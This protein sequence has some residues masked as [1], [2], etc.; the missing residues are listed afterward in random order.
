MRISRTPGAV[1]AFVLAAATFVQPLAAGAVT[2]GMGGDVAF[3]SGDGVVRLA[4]AD[5][6]S[7]IDLADGGHPVWSPDGRDLAFVSAA[8]TLRV[9]SSGVEIAPIEN[10]EWSWSPDGGSIAWVS[11][12]GVKDLW[13]T[14]VATATSKN[15]TNGAVEARSPQ[16]LPDGRTI[17]FEGSTGSG[18]HLWMVPAA[19]GAA[20]QVVAGH[21]AAVSS[22]GA[23]IALWSMDDSLER[24][25]VTVDRTGANPIVLATIT[26]C[27]FRRPSWSPDDS[28][29]GYAVACGGS[30]VLQAIEF[31]VVPA[32]GGRAKLIGGGGAYRAAGPFWSPTG[33]R[34]ALVAGG[35]SSRDVTIVD[36][37]GTSPVVL[38][39]LFPTGSC[40]GAPS[41]SPDGMR[42]A[43]EAYQSGC[44]Q[45]AMPPPPPAEI[46]LVAEDGTGLTSLG[47][48]AHPAWRPAPYHVGLVD[49]AQGVWHLNGIAPFYFGNPGDVPFL[50]D[51]D[52]DGVATPG[53]YRQSDG[54]VYLRNSNTQG[55][56]DIRFF[57]GNPG[58]IP[59][60]GDFDGDGI[61]TVSVYRPSTGEVFVI[62]ELGAND[63][64]LGA[65]EFA[66]YFGNP[67]DKPF[68][69]DFD[70]DG[71]D[72][73][74]LHRESTG[75]V[76]LRNSHTGGIADLSF[77]F[78]N[79]GDRLVAG[80]WTGD[81]HET[82]GVFRPAT[83]MF[84]L[85]FTNTQGNAD[86][87]FVAGKHSWIPVAGPFGD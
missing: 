3:T 80:D 40:T 79:P 18:D 42:L 70:G 34:L 45:P 23:R 87:S 84:H 65:A 21:D 10:L 74:G 12:S 61:D 56:A 4:S 58:D 54:Y 22:D 5:G 24:T 63:G 83:T 43:F 77:Y 67:G 46:H 68:V 71:I 35:W 27:S 6:N 52:G 64:G 29:I 44:T 17:V 76:Y 13:V 2:I 72:T 20:T 41:W 1:A 32:R 60:A 53:L 31:F 85:R 51:W 55:V 66:Y 28:L 25:L 57:F 11:H 33:D 39:D 19:G 7:V 59:V 15:L 47:S 14:D 86:A 8:G 37:D 73:V 78:G 38:T 62:N 75:L 82:V 49:P 16:W 69:G 30:P 50:G 36:P 81:G 26:G 48:G 9:L